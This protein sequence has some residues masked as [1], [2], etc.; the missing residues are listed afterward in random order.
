M[1]EVQLG[2]ALMV[3]TI[4]TSIAGAVEDQV[5]ATRHRRGR[6]VRTAAESLGQQADRLR[7]QVNDFPTN[8]R[9]A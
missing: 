3:S 8:I 9:A 2:K 6:C 7:G 4:A 5:A 1:K